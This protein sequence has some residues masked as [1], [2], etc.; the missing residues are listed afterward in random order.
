MM[1]ES[2]FSFSVKSRTNMLWASYWKR[3]I[4]DSGSFK[5]AKGQEETLVT[6]LII[7]NRTW[8]KWL[9][10]TMMLFIL[11]QLVWKYLRKISYLNKLLIIIKKSSVKGWVKIQLWNFLLAQ[12]IVQKIKN[13]NNSKMKFIEYLNCD[14]GK[15]KFV[16]FIKLRDAF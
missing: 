6:L 16:A 15:E 12:I 13:L 2:L 7:V 14:S 3:K 11:L 1:N 5:C 8:W 9:R 4:L 10:D